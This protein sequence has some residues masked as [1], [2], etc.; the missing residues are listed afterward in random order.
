M[1]FIVH[2]DMLIR[3]SPDMPPNV[4]RLSD[5]RASRQAKKGERI[6]LITVDEAF[7]QANLIIREHNNLRSE[8]RESIEKETAARASTC[9]KYTMADILQVL[10]NDKKGRL[11]AASYR[12]AIARE[13]LRRLDPRSTSGA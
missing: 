9:E 11:Y 5:A 4:L 2:R 3:M 7:H 10:T 1:T 6:P 12:L 13:T 8:A